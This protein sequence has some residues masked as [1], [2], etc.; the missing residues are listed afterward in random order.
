MTAEV[1]DSHLPC[2][3]ELCLK[4]LNSLLRATHFCQTL[5]EPTFN[6]WKQLR[7][8]QVK[9]GKIIS[10][11]SPTTT[12]LIACILFRSALPL[13]LPL[14]ETDSRRKV[15]KRRW[16]CNYRK[17]LHTSLLPLPLLPLFLSQFPLFHFFTL[18][19]LF[20]QLLFVFF[21]SSK[22]QKWSQ[23]YANAKK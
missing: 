18:S 15:E 13:L 6:T 3:W 14:T 17:L 11:P 1:G 19:P 4:T 16:A 2:L 5:A 9:G 21:F 8:W 20:F 22:L 10:Y 23:L 7:F 12:H